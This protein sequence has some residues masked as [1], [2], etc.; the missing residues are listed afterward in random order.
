M[1][2]HN[3]YGVGT[4]LVD[5]ENAVVELRRE[6]REL[7][8]HL[9]AQLQNLVKDATSTIQASL[10]I[11]QDG[12]D[13]KDGA[14]GRD[15]Q[16]IKGDKGE[17]GDVLYVTPEEVTAQVQELRLKLAKWQAA[18]QFAY[19]QNYGTKHQGLKRAIEDTL[20]TVEKRA[21]S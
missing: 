8:T 14:P 21:N 5:L 7:R 9:G 15:G 18:I 19:E 1:T 11:P 4:R 2:S 16:S 10:R 13:G 12:R 3:K 6:N 20:K 17:R